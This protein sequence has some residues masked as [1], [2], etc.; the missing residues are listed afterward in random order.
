MKK[1]LS[2]TLWENCYWAKNFFSMDNQSGQIIVIVVIS[3]PLIT[4]AKI[5]PKMDKK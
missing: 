4:K 1:N 3:L 5:P 2:K